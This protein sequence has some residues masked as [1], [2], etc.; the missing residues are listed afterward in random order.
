MEIKHPVRNTKLV[1]DFLQ[2]VA[3][4]YLIPALDAFLIYI[5]GN[6]GRGL[7]HYPPRKYVSRKQAGYKTSAKQIRFMFATGILERTSG[8]GIK[9]NRYKRTDETKNAWQIVG[10]GT[11]R[12]S[13][14]NSRAYYTMDDRGQARQPA[15]V[16]WRK[17]T[18]VIRDNLKGA[19]NAAVSAISKAIKSKAK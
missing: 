16:G 4:G 13:L 14:V 12:P 8:G 18:N 5:L 3:K 11:Y 6:D 10:Q 19:I 2:H 1:Q 7:K 15:L 17:V 9:L